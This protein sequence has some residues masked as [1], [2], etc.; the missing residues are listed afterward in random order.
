[1]VAPSFNLPTR[2]TDS[3]K[4]VMIYRN[5]STTKR[6]RVI[7][8]HEDI[9]MSFTKRGVDVE[10]IKLEDMS[11]Q[12]TAIKLSTAKFLIGVLISCCPFCAWVSKM[13]YM[14]LWSAH[15]DCWSL[16]VALHPALGV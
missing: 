13:A 2:P 5:P 6:G 11:L 16:R 14:L 10:L 1:M 7:L 3:E 8:N 9:M 12:E 4:V 15:L